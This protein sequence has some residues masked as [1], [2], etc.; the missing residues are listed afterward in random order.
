MILLSNNCDCVF[1]FSPS[2]ANNWMYRKCFY[3]VVE[4]NK[5]RWLLRV[6]LRQKSHTEKTLL[7]NE[8]KR[9]KNALN[10]LQTG[11]VS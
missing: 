10:V 8:M 1:P 9:V 5:Q 6:L 4:L 3:R 11:S 2:Q 7:L